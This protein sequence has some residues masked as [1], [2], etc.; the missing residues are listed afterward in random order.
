MFVHSLPGTSGW[1]GPTLVAHQEDV[2]LTLP[3]RRGAAPV[4]HTATA[5]VN[6][7]STG[8]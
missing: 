5:T 3:S 4:A 7:S 2:H 6:G 1:N 8:S